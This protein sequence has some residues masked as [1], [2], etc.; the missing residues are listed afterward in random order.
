M[1]DEKS[2]SEQSWATS[3]LDQGLVA[4]TTFNVN[5][6]SVMSS[7]TK[8]MLTSLAGINSSV[9]TTAWRMYS[10]S[11]IIMT[12]TLL[13]RFL[14]VCLEFIQR[15]GAFLRPFPTSSGRVKRKPIEWRFEV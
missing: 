4:P 12:N 10:E 3:T 14:K 1:E 6:W 11:D 15:I 5:D 7:S 13:L 9:S 2:T 8:P